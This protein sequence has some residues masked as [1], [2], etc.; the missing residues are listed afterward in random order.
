[1]FN[2]NEQMS[3]FYAGCVQLGSD[4]K[5]KLAGYRDT[6]LERL[7]SG[8]AK[9]EEENGGTYPSYKYYRNQGSYAMRTLNQHPENDYDL[10]VALIFKQGDLP[11]LPSDARGRI[12]Q[13]LKAGGGNFSKDPEART[14]AVTVWY[15]EGYHIDLAIYREVVGFG[16]A[17]AIEHAGG[18]DW[19][20]RDPMEI[21]NWFDQKVKE[22]SPAKEWGATTEPEQMRRIVQ[23]LKVFARSRSSWSLPGGLIISVLVVECYRPDYHR[24]DVALYNTIVAIRNRLLL[25]AE[26]KNPVDAQLKLTDKPKYE[27]QVKRLRERLD[28]AISKLAVL[29]T[30]DCTQAA[31]VKAWNWFFNHAYWGETIVEE[32]D[33]Q[34]AMKALSLERLRIDARLAMRKGGTFTQY[35]PSGSRVLPK[36]I[37]LYFTVAN[38]TVSPPYSI[39]WVVQN[40]GDEAK[41][42]NDMGHVS[43][44]NLPYH[45][46]RTLYKGH[47]TMTCELLKNGV[48]MARAIHL[49]KIK[50]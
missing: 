18:S 35:Y 23:L 17:V 26:V 44:T 47:H 9:L 21:T 8:L 16:E 29:W 45:W 6:N 12:E 32:D 43:A 25:S 13:G 20:A 48:V 19:T 4:E 24:D 37:W 39:R 31:A 46:E 28:Q 15:A 7:R 2:L 42:A 11:S 40:H 38:T 41:E 50:E 14:N 3:Q 27:S 36:N 1:M 30:N 5:D 22:C 49:V 10:D 34:A 33:A